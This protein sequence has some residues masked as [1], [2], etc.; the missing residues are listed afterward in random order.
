VRRDDAPDPAG[1]ARP[2]PSPILVWN[3]LVTRVRRS[4][5]ER[6]DGKLTSTTFA[7]PGRA[8]GTA[9]RTGEKQ[10]DDRSAAERVS[11]DVD[12]PIDLVGPDLP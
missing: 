9:A 5:G 1:A 2:D 6:Q 8:P 12:E 11:G 10:R 3:G 4:V 7:D